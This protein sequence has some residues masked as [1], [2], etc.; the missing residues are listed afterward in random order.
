ME[1]INNTELEQMKEQM[2][3]LK[4]KIE[5]EKIVNQQLLRV[6]MKEKVSSL[7]RDAIIFVILGIVAI[8]YCTWVFISILNMSWW[9]IGVTDLF[10]LAAIVY[11]YFSHKDIKAKELMDGNLI[12]VSKKIMRMRRMIGANYRLSIGN[13]DFNLLGGSVLKEFAR[14]GTFCTLG[15]L[16]NIIPARNRAIL[17][18]DF[19]QTNLSMLSATW[20]PGKNSGDEFSS[21]DGLSAD[22]QSPISI[23]SAGAFIYHEFGN[24]T[25]YNTFHSGIYS[26]INFYGLSLKPEVILQSG[27]NNN[28][29]FYSFGAE[30]QLI[31]DNGQ[32]TRLMG[33]YVGMKKIDNSA[34]ATMSFSNIFAGEV[35]RLDAMDMPFLQAGIKHSFTNWKASIKLQGALQTG[36]ATNFTPDDYNT[37]PSKMKELDLTFSKNIGK[38]LLINATV[39]YLNYPEL[40]TDSQAL[41]KYK[42]DHS[43]W[44]KVELRLTF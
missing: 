6:A 19:G 32:Q 22:K 20:R 7:N 18:K 39:G 36:E 28:A 34:V 21:N 3:L 38:L 8:P 13:I 31:W 5:K 33:R 42:T 14:N 4:E 26:D 43:A 1:N 9:F 15:Y 16:Y 10:F 44:G 11:T 41:L 2:N 30:K 24:W 29:L 25:T 27:N 40:S 37:T 12:E 17:G 23:N 35:L